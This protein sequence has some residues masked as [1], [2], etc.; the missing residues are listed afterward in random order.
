VAETNNTDIVRKSLVVVID[1]DGGYL[2]L[3]VKN[4]KAKYDWD[5]KA[6]TITQEILQFV[7]ENAKEIDVVVADMWLDTP[8]DGIELL[9]QIGKIN[10]DIV[11]I[12]M[13]GKDNPKVAKQAVARTTMY[14]FI[15]KDWAVEG[16]G[17]V[18]KNALEKRAISMALRQQVKVLEKIQDD[19]FHQKKFS[20]IGELI[21]GTC[22]NLNTPLGV[23]IGHAELMKWE[24]ES[25]KNPEV[26]CASLL[27]H[28]NTIQDAA[29]RIQ[30]IIQNLII[31]SR[32]DQEIKI[33]E[34]SLNDLIERELKF[35]Q[36]DVFLRHKVDTTLDLADDLP[37]LRCNYGDLSQVFSNLIRNAMDAMFETK[38]PRLYISTKYFAQE[39]W[40]EVH[41]NGP[42]VPLDIRDKIFM[43]YFSTKAHKL[44]QF[45][46]DRED[47]R[48]FSSGIGLG[49]HSVTRLLA[50]YNAKVT[51]DDSPLGG[52]CFRLIFPRK[53]SHVPN[54]TFTP[55]AT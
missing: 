31:K 35:L 5:I 49:L 4:L 34:L 41:D 40:L 24:L 13:T 11:K 38:N 30:D 48:V 14:G 52:A 19:L 8:M 17:I 29:D 16:I 18:L 36:A 50:T 46:A 55:L 15:D 23:I 42:G 25:I 3:L 26:N 27:N 22:H 53:P 10:E 37:K 21:Q 44:L 7:Q 2:N 20:V 43:P 54:P 28:L 1:D 51:V 12:L 9:E 33:H 6:F 32:M 45:G 39:I 47:H